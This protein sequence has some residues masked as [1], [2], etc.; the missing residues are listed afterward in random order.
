[1]A[2]KT[3]PDLSSTVPVIP[4]NVCC[5]CAAADIDINNKI[6][7]VRQV[8]Q[9]SEFNRAKVNE[10]T[11]D[12][13]LI[14]FGRP[15]ETAYFSRMQREVWSYRYMANNIDYMMFHFYFDA[16]GILRLTQK[17]PDPMRDRNLRRGF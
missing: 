12:D 10:W 17:T 3:A 16:Q 7:S 15:A 4:P 11:R 1:M 14:N 2:G 9:E 6:L 13:V 5:A 8:L